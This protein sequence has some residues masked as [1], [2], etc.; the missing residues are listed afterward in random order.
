[1]EEPKEHSWDVDPK[2][3]AEREAE[4]AEAELRPCPGCGKPPTVS[5]PMGTQIEC[6]TGCMDENTLYG[7]GFTFAQAPNNWDD[8][9]TRWEEENEDGD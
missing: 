1:M 4:K 9:I 7:L 8:A 6:S 5:R 3:R 2:E